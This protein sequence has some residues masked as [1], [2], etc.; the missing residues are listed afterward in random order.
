MSVPMFPRNTGDD[1][2][3]SKIKSSECHGDCGNLIKQTHRG[4]LVC[5]M[6]DEYRKWP[7]YTGGRK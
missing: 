5:A 1:D 7:D 2:A 3:N 6:C 4:V